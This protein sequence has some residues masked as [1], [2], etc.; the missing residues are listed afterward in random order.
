MYF[1]SIIFGI[2]V[3]QILDVSVSTLNPLKSYFVNLILYS[4][5]VLYSNVIGLTE[6]ALSLTEVYVSLLGYLMI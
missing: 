2:V 5:I 6:A 1:F 3:L 4:F